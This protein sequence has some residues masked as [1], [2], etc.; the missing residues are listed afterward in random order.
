MARH[1]E[2]AASPRGRVKAIDQKPAP[3]SGR[4]FCNGGAAEEALR[5]W[6]EGQGYL[7]SAPPSEASAPECDFAVPFA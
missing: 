2:C 3:S 5:A 7:A 4:E 6:A 1:L